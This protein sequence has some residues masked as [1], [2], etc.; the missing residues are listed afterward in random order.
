VSR[1]KQRNKELSLTLVKGRLSL[2][3]DEKAPACLVRS[4]EER[5]FAVVL[6]PAFAKLPSPVASHP[7][8][9]LHDLGGELL[10]YREYYIENQMLFEGMTV[11]L[12]DH[13]AGDTY[14]KDIGM[15][16]LCLGKTLFCLPSHTC[17]EILSGREIVPVRQG[18]AACACLKVGENAI[19]TSDI[20][21][22]K[23][24][25]KRGVSVLRIRPGC[26]DLPG[27]DCGSCGSPTCRAFA[28]DIVRG[29]FTENACIHKM[30]E[31]IKRMAQQM[32]DLAQISSYEEKK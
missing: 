32:I 12:T 8:L 16:A 10:V 19:V 28:E 11:K 18:Y 3:L 6:L 13:A 1:N 24:A 27:Y 25:E 22:A 31:Q 7:D 21:I 9:L 14:P 20:G 23:E 4:L 15:D 30:R 5:G 29:Y 2:F 17:P 26:I